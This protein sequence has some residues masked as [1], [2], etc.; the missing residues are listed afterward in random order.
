MH[1]VFFLFF[2]LM[3]CLYIS[4][5]T[6]EPIEVREIE[7]P[8]L[9]KSLDS[10][11]DL[12]DQIFVLKKA[13]E[14]GPLHEQALMDILALLEAELRE[15][16][17]PGS[18][19]ALEQWGKA[20]GL[21]RGL[22]SDLAFA[23]W[24][25]NFRK[26]LGSAKITVDQY[27]ELV[28][29][30]LKVSGLQSYV[31]LNRWGEAGD[32]SLALKRRNL[33]ILQTLESEVVQFR[34]PSPWDMLRQ[35]KMD[36]LLKQNAKRFCL[37]P[38]KKSLW[39]QWEKTLPGPIY[40]YWQAQA[41]LACAGSSFEER[42]KSCQKAADLLSSEKKYGNQWLQSVYDLIAIY[43]AT[44]D[45]ESLASSYRQLV[46]VWRVA[47]IDPQVMQIRAEDLFARHVDDLLWASRAQA[48]VGKYD[49]TVEYAQEALEILEEIFVKFPALNKARLVTMANLKAETLHLMASR[50]AI[51]QGDLAM[52]REYNA[53]AMKI[54]Q[55]SDEWRVRLRWSEGLYLYMA[56]SLK[57]AAGVWEALLPDVLEDSSI[58]PQVL[59]WL[60]RIHTTLDQK[61][62]A[63]SW[64][65][66]LER[67]FPW[68][69]YATVAFGLAGVNRESK[70]V[71]D[72]FAGFQ[73]QSKRFH[74]SIGL[75]LGDWQS[76][77]A[78]IR[79]ALIRLQGSLAIK[80][81][82]FSRMLSAELS[83]GLT[84]KDP[85]QQMQDLWIY[86]SRLQYASGLMGD[87]VATTSRLAQKS[88][89]FWREHPEQFFAFFPRPFLELFNEASSRH[90]VSASL[91]LGIARQ[92]ST[93]NPSARSPAG[94]L[95]IA[96]I[97]PETARL[98]IEPSQT[99]DSG[100]LT[101][102][103]L[104]PQA[105]LGLS[106]KLLG[107]LSEKYPQ[108]LAA[109]VAAYNAGE[110]AVDA[111]QKRRSSEDQLVWI[112][113]IPFS[114]TKS[115]VRNVWRNMYVY[116]RIASL[117]QEPIAYQDARRLFPD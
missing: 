101:S 41:K 47:S 31:N 20:L 75:E 90:G 19:E 22:L 59:F 82:D 92:E 5:A 95:G 108:S 48:L 71:E 79:I 39:A 63:E 28:L 96:Q 25:R 13:S 74:E 77:D 100:D 103:L 35:A 30:K 36:P 3:A 106:S 32:V 34:E 114:E 66:M 86:T 109:V 29:T 24:N 62:I 43:R 113:L 70:Y 99:R 33:E 2:A 97:M 93:F 44:G 80:R 117:R 17:S 55:I 38:D 65:A 69:F 45:R 84:K 67:E 37:A 57:E 115:Y 27:A 7:D 64:A 56:G 10:A 85:K 88:P 51:E 105:N 58:R 107:S 40:A 50:V 12:K 98:L 111:W 9:P 76:V 16:S 78:Q 26:S 1:K 11:M 116:E 60:A 91:L 15:Q 8:V 83:S 4:C 110:Y 14:K 104:D 87:A 46:K 23:G 54:D 53:K 49:V 52:A 89:S 61:E 72:F 94:A 18:R 42:A 112:E 102:L 68:S 81:L 6:T 73:D 21:S